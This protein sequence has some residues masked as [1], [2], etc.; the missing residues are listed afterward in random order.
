MKTDGLMRVVRMT[1][2]IAAC[3]LFLHVPL[4]A[5]PVFPESA[6]ATT[7]A[8]RSSL[9][10]GETVVSTSDLDD[11]ITSVRGM[12]RVDAPAASIWRALTDYDNQKNF[13]PKV[14]E[15]G[16]ISE[17]GTEQEMFSVGRTGV[18]FF[19]KTV[20]I[21]LLLKG[22]YPKR[23]SFRQTKGDFKLYR[24]E[25]TITRLEGVPGRVLTF[26]AHIKPDFFAPDFFVRAVQKK[27][28]PG[29]LLAMK[30]RAE[31]MAGE[32]HGAAGKLP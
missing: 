18:L 7:S 5:L 14:R 28:L 4:L 21:Q 27:D 25:W 8:E 23:L 17:N 9:A 22:D 30:E 32:I 3:P 16:L 13:V 10:D 11:G 29:I 2:L 19:K 12:I 1:L 26:R 20:T 6:P 31:G 15:S 24:G